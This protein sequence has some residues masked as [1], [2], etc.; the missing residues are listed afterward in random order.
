MFIVLFTA[1]LTLSNPFTI[2]NGSVVWQQVYDTSTDIETMQQYL[3]TQGSLTDVQV[4]ANQIT[5]TI[6]TPIDLSAAGAKVM[7]T[8]MYIS[9]YDYKGRFTVQFKDNRYRVT[10]SDIVLVQTETDIFGDVGTTDTFDSYIMRKGEFKKAF[11]K[12]HYKIIHPT[13]LNIF[14]LQQLD[15]DW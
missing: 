11:A 2:V 3:L 6:S 7:G 5:G 8:P 14:T 9:K 15:T 12:K 10:I 1:F 13:F 4:V